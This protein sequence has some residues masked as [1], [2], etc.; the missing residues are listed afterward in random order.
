[1]PSQ[2]GAGLFQSGMPV[3]LRKC[4]GPVVR[5]MRWLVRVRGSDGAEERGRVCGAWI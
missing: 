2:I 1:M 5:E 4:S 3:L